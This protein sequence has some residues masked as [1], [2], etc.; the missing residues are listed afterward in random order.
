MVF[1]E[2]PRRHSRNLGVIESTKADSEAI[3]KQAPLCLIIALWKPHSKR[4][5]AAGGIYL[6]QQPV[7]VFH[8]P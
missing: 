6:Q 7:R 5:K 8:A 1:V 3:C 4:E 2:D